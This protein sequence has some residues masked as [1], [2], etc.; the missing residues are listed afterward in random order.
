MQGNACVRAFPERS[1]GIRY[2]RR[3]GAHSVSDC[4]GKAWWERS[5]D[6]D[7]GDMPALCI[8]AGKTWIAARWS[9]ERSRSGMVQQAGMCR[10]GT[11]LFAQGRIINTAVFM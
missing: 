9:V 4:V 5:R 1:G 6:I 11:V 2:V 10:E 8:V 3:N 7:G